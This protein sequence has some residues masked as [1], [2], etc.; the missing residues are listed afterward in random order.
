MTGLSEP[1]TVSSKVEVE[2]LTIPAMWRLPL[3][4][5][6]VRQAKST[7]VATAGGVTSFPVVLNCEHERQ[8]AAWATAA[9]WVA[10]SQRSASMAAMQPEPA[11]VIA[12]RYVWSCTSPQANTPSMLVY[13]EPAAVTR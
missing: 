7:D 11:A 3:G 5:W 12:W 4:V 8:F 2:R 13:D 10:S 1:A 6:P 9:W